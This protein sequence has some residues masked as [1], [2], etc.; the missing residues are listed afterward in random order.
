[1][2]SH[3]TDEVVTIVVNGHA[4]AGTTAITS[5]V[6]D[7]LGFDAARVMAITA[8]CTSGSVLTLDLKSNTINGTTGSPVKEAT[9]TVTSASA[10]DCDNKALITD[11]IKPGGR[12][13]YGVFTPATQNCELAC[14]IIE[15]YRA[16]A[17]PVTQDATTV[18]TAKA[19]SGG[20]V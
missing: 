9:S 17:M 11:V 8:D 14:I 7:T 5:S 19:V 1:M 2:K 18:A 13:V 15:L 10:T 16:K 12:Y 4:A 6:V 20:S 3:M